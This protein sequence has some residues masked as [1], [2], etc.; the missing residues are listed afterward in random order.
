MGDILFEIY[1]KLLG[2]I[3]LKRKILKDKRSFY[4]HFTPIGE[5]AKTIVLHLP[6]LNTKGSQ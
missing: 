4:S 6:G 2:E 1:G 5:L 3:I